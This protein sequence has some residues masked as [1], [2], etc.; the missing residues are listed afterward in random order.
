VLAVVLL[1][2]GLF[3]V[4]MV[5][6]SMGIAYY[7]ARPEKCPMA[8]WLPPEGVA[9]RCDMSGGI[10]FQDIFEARISEAGATAY[11]K[12]LLGDLKNPR[13]IDGTGLNARFEVDGDVQV[14]FS[15][16]NGVLIVDYIKY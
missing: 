6:G 12:G 2:V 3:V 5:L 11:Q 10:D 7:A 1:H 16:E 4:G 9:T 8:A 15:W 14:R 13:V